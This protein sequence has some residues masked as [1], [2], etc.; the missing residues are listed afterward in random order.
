YTATSVETIKKDILHARNFGFNFL[1]VHIK[2]DDPL[3]LHWADKLGV[4]LMCDFPNFGEG[5]DTLLGRQRFETMMRETIERDFNHPSIFAWCLFNETWGFGGQTSFVDKL[6][7]PFT[8]GKAGQNRKDV[9]LKPA[10]PVPGMT[11]PQVWVQKMW[12]LGKKLDPTRL[13]EDMSVCH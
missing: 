13:I 11:L 12:E 7:E 10:G 6:Q 5:G 3:L 4:L 8:S 1:R 9:P 2:V